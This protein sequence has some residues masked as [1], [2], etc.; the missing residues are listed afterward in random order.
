MK[1][2]LSKIWEK[3]V[4]IVDALTG[5][6]LYVIPMV[7]GTMV[8]VIGVF[9]IISVFGAVDDMDKSIRSIPAIVQTEMQKTRETLRQEGDANRQVIV[10]QHEATRDELV[11]KLNAAEDERKA[12]KAALDKLEKGQTKVQN[13]IDQVP[14]QQKRQKVLGI[15]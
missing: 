8:V 5:K 15:F 12:T 11:Q 3:L 14:K 1:I 9:V 2:W 13:Q 7:M 4:A 6:Y 10:G